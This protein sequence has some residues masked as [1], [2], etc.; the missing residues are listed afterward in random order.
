M[1]CILQ[2]MVWYTTFFGF[3]GIGILRDFFRIPEY[4]RDVNE[5]DKYVEQLT[6]KMRK[7]DKVM[8]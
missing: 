1:I 2:A 8:G 3:A 6:L 5:S 7:Y 4:V